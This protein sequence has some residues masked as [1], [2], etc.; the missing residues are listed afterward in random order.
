MLHHKISK[1]LNIATPFPA[2]HCCQ[3]QPG[4][5]E[6]VPVGR[7][8]IGVGVSRFLWRMN[9]RENPSDRHPRLRRRWPGLYGVASSSFLPLKRF[10]RFLIH[11]RFRNWNGGGRS[12]IAGRP[13]MT[14]LKTYPNVVVVGRSRDGCLSQVLNL[15]VP[16]VA[17]FLNV[18][19]KF[20]KRIVLVP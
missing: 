10:R 5:R 13:L 16:N 7:R 11:H 14:I 6:S 19:S 20:Y 3:S 4:G 8:E 9:C 2:H 12:T 18:I 15:V 17:V 1:R